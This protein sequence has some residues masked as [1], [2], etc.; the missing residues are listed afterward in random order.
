MILERNLILNIR[1]V[2][3]GEAKKGLL[4]CPRKWAERLEGTVAFLSEENE[5]F[6]WDPGEKKRVFAAKTGSWGEGCPHIAGGLGTT[7][8]PVGK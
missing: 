4:V 2:E 5:T 8:L 6:H 1:K 7:L 3:L